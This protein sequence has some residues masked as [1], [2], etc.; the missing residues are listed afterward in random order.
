MRTFAELLTEYTRR[1]GVSDSEL[2]RALGVRRQ[3]IF[4]WKEGLTEKPR[5]REDVLLCAEKLRLTPAER[6]ALLLAAGFAPEA[7]VAAEP[8]L[9][10]A[11]P[12][13]TPTIAPLP[14]TPVRPIFRWTWI[15]VALALLIAAIGALAFALTVPALSIAPAAPGETLVIIAAFDSATPATPTSVARFAPVAAGN[16]SQRLQAAFERESRAAR[17]ERI[18][19]TI[20]STPITD[21]RLAEQIRARANATLVIWGTL[22]GDELTAGL[23]HAPEQFR[24]ND[25][26]LDALL[27]APEPRAKISA[28]VGEELQALALF[29]LSYIYLDRGELDLARAG[30]IQAQARAPLDPETRAALNAQTGFVLQMLKPSELGQAI[31]FY[32]QTLDFAPA[33]GAAYLNRGVAYLRLNDAQAQADLQRAR[34]LLPNEARGSLAVCWAHVLAREPE[35]GLP[36]CDAAVR[37]DAGGRNREARAIVLA[38]LGKFPDA[39][40][41]LQLFTD[42]LARQPASLRARYGATRAEWLGALRAGKNPFDEATLEKLRRE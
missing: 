34:E 29:G 23:A 41:D 40:N 16:T 7:P 9:S 14:I 13:E 32:S 28:L 22:A 36:F 10:V 42:W 17:L 8:S 3:T 24:A 33:L 38:Q 4:R 31:Q 19:I 2:A 6:D 21:A 39:V 26:A 27:V 30:L 1:T 25:L 37:G 35:R 20:L 11:P 15:A 5:H 18:R 12:L